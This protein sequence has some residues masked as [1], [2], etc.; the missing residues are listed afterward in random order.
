MSTT[1]ITSS[2]VTSVHYLNPRKGTED[3]VQMHYKKGG[4]RVYITLIPVRGRKFPGHDDFKIFTYVYI[5]LIP[6]RGRKTYDN[7]VRIGGF[8]GV[9]YLNPRKGTEDYIKLL[10]KFFFTRVHYL[11]PRKGTE[12]N[13]PF[14]T[15]SS[16][17]CVYITLI[18]VRG[19]KN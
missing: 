13:S 2:I 9:H 14:V 1:S 19:R 18:P 4:G 7:I 17:S 6:V 10:F 8:S 16:S 5:T 12:E 15:L 3:I 11:N